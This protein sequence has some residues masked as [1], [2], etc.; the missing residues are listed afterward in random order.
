[1]TVL[2]HIRVSP[3]SFIISRRLSGSA[4]D[5]RSYSIHLSARTLPQ[6]KQRT[7]TIMVL[8]LTIVINSL[9][10]NSLYPSQ[11]QKNWYFKAIETIKINCMPPLP[12]DIKNAK[13]SARKVSSL[14]KKYNDG[15]LTKRALKE[16]I[17]P[18]K[19][20][21]TESIRCNKGSSCP[22]IKS[23]CI[24]L[25]SV[26]D[27]IKTSL[28]CKQRAN[29]EQCEQM[30]NTLKHLIEKQVLY[31]DDYTSLGEIMQAIRKL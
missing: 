21:I 23:E 30:E 17:S 26:L 1:M 5:R 18:M 22:K 20:E 28:A 27:T 29:Q 10:K 16:H 24:F 25:Q 9:N 31:V 15:Q 13:S 12:P 19:S 8:K 3:N 4:R 7:G 6:V 11:P 2:Q 14:V